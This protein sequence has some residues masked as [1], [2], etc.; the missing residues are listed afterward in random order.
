M[1]DK[2]AT[3]LADTERTVSE[4]L[5]ACRYPKE[6]ILPVG[7]VEAESNPVSTT[8]SSTSSS[9][10]T[11][12]LLEIEVDKADPKC[13]N[14]W[15]RGQVRVTFRPKQFGGGAVNVSQLCGCV[16]KKAQKIANKSLPE[17]TQFRVKLKELKKDEKVESK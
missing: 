11:T 1:P 10:S 14:C 15:G 2:V 9:S 7:F 12:T 4:S 17:G 16:L 13:T 6:G 3:T 8:T 5:E